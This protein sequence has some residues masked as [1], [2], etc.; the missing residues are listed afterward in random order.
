[1]ANYRK[2][3]DRDLVEHYLW[4]K[5]L[6]EIFEERFQVKPKI[7]RDDMEYGL[8]ICI[9]YFHEKQFV[10]DANGST[11]IKKVSLEL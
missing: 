11:V 9:F 6:C 2:K 7:D 5:D 10:V 3:S 4:G 1:L 8:Y